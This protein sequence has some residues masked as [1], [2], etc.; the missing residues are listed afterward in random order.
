MD[1]SSQLTSFQLSSMESSSSYLHV[2]SNKML[3]SSEMVHKVISHNVYLRLFWTTKD[4]DKVGPHHFMSQ[5]MVL[6]GERNLMPAHTSGL[7]NLG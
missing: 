5:F 2:F 4:P 1:K 3:S 6:I 7:S